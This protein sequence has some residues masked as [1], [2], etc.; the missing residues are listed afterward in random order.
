V[1][2]VEIDASEHCSFLLSSV[3]LRITTKGQGH[4]ASGV[5]TTTIGVA[6]IV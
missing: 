5:V 6:S 2:K 3:Y 1:F 4:Q